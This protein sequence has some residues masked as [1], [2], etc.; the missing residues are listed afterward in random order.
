MDQ[1]MYAYLYR[2]CMRVIEEIGGKFCECK[3]QEL[4]LKWKDRKSDLHAIDYFINVNSLKKK[5]RE[6]V[7]QDFERESY[8][9]AKV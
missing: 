2:S 6:R 7:R 8:D 4:K 3:G 5:S 1:G 9:L